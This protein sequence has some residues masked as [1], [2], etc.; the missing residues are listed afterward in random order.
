VCA[1]VSRG[2]SHCT[3]FALSDAE[4]PTDFRIFLG[5]GRGLIRWWAVDSRARNLTSAVD[6]YA[7]KRLARWDFLGYPTNLPSTRRHRCDI[8]WR[9]VLS[10]DTQFQKGAMLARPA[11]ECSPHLWAGVDPMRRSRP[12]ASEK[13]TS[14]PRSPPARLQGIP[15]GTELPTQRNFRPP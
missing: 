13:S 3:E 1:G 11:R 7:L 8:R 12:T 10:V 5:F 2:V 6:F 9:R 15:S 14:P 4:R